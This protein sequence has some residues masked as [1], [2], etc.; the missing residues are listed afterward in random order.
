MLSQFPHDPVP[1]NCQE[2]ELS[3]PLPDEDL[4]AMVCCVRN[5]THHNEV[6]PLCSWYVRLGLSDLKIELAWKVPPWQ[7]AIAI[8]DLIPPAS[9]QAIVN[10]IEGRA[11][12][13]HS[14]V[15]END[16]EK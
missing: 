14:P 13:N 1:T 3:F 8:R 9:L 7:K 12:D 2:C 16:H 15:Q 5:I 11:A 6:Q 4:V 10:I